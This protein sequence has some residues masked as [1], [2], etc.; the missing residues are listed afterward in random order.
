VI[1]YAGAP[2]SILPRRDDVL[3]WRLSEVGRIVQQRTFAT[4]SLSAGSGWLYIVDLTG[5]IQPD[6]VSATSTLTN[7]PYGCLSL[8]AR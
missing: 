8:S 3:R 7:I 4:D 6:P 2:T 1:A 5:S